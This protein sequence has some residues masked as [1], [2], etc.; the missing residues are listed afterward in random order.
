M[1]VQEN[2]ASYPDLGLREKLDWW[3]F[4]SL[5]SGGIKPPFKVKLSGPLLVGYLYA[6]RAAGFL[7]RIGLYFLV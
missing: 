5:D 4:L 3:V 1:D 7:C 6:N 2:T